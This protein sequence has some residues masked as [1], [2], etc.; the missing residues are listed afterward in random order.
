[1]SR[2]GGVSLLIRAALAAQRYRHPLRTGLQRLLRLPVVTV[3]DRASGLSFQC[4][5]GADRILGAV[6]HTREYD[7]PTA[8]VSSEHHV[9][10]IGANHGMV[11]CW[12]ASRGASVHA[13]EPNPAVFQRLEHNLIRNGLSE[14][15]SARRAAVGGVAAASARLYLSREHGGGLSTLRKEIASQA[16]ARFHTSVDVEVLDIRGVIASIAPARV[17]LLKLDCE[18]CE[19][20]ILQAL[21]RNSRELI[22]SIALEYHE[23][24]YSLDAL[25][26]LVGDWGEWS[27]SKLPDGNVQNHILHLVSRQAIREWGASPLERMPNSTPILA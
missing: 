14:R 11:S 6:V 16:E 12:F 4:L 18:G 27:I 23:S 19:L 1:M 13:F 15:V 26:E 24:A 5:R 7:I 3:T 17:R 21:D 25:L 10:D 8:P 20:D 2:I 9:V 22:D